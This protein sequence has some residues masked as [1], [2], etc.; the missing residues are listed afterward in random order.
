MAPFATH[1]FVGVS[2]ALAILICISYRYPD[3]IKYRLT[4][5]AIGA[6]W[7]VV[8]DVHHIVPGDRMRIIHDTPWADVFALHYTL[9]RPLVRAHPIESLFLSFALF[10]VLVVL[11]EHRRR[12]IADA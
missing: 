8:P 10:F 7:G 5:V 12:A 11:T 2:I 1:A 9:D 4:A 3:A 6:L